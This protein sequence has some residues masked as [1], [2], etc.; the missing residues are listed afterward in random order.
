MIPPL[1]IAKVFVEY[2]HAAGREARSNRV[3]H[4]FGR[5][6]DATINKSGDAFVRHVCNRGEALNMTSIVTSQQ[7]QHVDKLLDRIA[8]RLEGRES[9]ESRTPHTSISELL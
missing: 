7:R 9:K 8:G 1:R 5:K 4:F 2:D 6:I 3:E